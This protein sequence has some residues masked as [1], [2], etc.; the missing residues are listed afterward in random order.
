MAAYFSALLL[1]QGLGA[2]FGSPRLSVEECCTHKIMQ[3]N[4]HILS[5]DSF[6]VRNENLL[7]ATSLQSFTYVIHRFRKRKHIGK[8]DS[9]L[10]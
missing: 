9:S 7:N 4:T 1:I 6:K 5:K 10:F 2:N 3:M 8:Q